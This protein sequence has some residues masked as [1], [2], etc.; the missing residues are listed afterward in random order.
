M[1]RYFTGINSVSFNK[2][3]DPATGI[4]DKSKNIEMD[5]SD[6]IYFIKNPISI[7]YNGSMIFLK[8]K[9]AARLA[10]D[11]A[12]EHGG[13]PLVLHCN[14]NPEELRIYHPGRRDYHIQDSPK[15]PVEKI[16]LVKS[17]SSLWDIELFCCLK[18]ISVDKY[19]EEYF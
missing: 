13:V 4:F 19:L 5:E 1:D 3:Y 7:S 11:L 6:K 15:T 12:G 18:E 17:F 2:G 9:V 14:P 8:R 10:K 16:F